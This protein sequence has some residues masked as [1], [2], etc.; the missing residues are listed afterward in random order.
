LP[1]SAVRDDGGRSVVWLIRDGRLERREVDAGPVSAGF[2]EIRSGLSGGELILTGGV[3]TPVA[4]MR[5]ETT[6]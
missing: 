3:E 1:S 4:G 2:R 5:V 6:P